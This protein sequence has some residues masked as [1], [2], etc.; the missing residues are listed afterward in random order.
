MGARRGDRV[1]LVSLSVLCWM[2][3]MLFSCARL[4]GFMLLAVM[5]D[6]ADTPVHGLVDYW[7]LDGIH[8]MTLPYETH[9]F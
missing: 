4:V 3:C 2:S 9:L 7:I 1:V 6:L 5:I 8:F